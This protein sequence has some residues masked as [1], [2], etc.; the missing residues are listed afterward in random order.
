MRQ[1]D[2]RMRRDRAKAQSLWE[3][4]ILLCLWGPP[5]EWKRY[6]GNFVFLCFLTFLESCLCGSWIASDWLHFPK[7]VYFLLRPLGSGEGGIPLIHLLATTGKLCFRHPFGFA[8]E[9]F[10]LPSA[11]VR[12]CRTGLTYIWSE[13][14]LFS[15]QDLHTM[16]RCASYS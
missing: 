4:G 11:F 6:F 15:R 9:V 13:K 10:F 1:R 16:V 8:A 5:E 3:L 14:P 7:L 12:F 2:N